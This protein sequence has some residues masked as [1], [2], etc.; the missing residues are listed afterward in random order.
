MPLGATLAGQVVH[1]ALERI[2]ESINSSPVTPEEPHAAV[3]GAS[4][5]YA[6]LRA[7]GGISA[8]VE[9]VIA[10]TVNEHRNNPRLAPRLEELGA[11]LRRQVPT[12]RQRVQQFLS[13]VDLSGV[14]PTRT[15]PV[16][17]T[18]ATL[19]RQ[20]LPPG[21]HAEVPLFNQEL[22]W[23][24]KADLLRIGIGADSPSDEIID[25]KT[26][27]PKPDHALQ[28]RI[29]ALLWARDRDLNPTGRRAQ[30]LRVLYP[31]GA[32]DIAAPKTDDAL[33]MVKDELSARTAAALSLI[34]VHPA[35]A[36][37]SFDSCQWCDVRH[38][39]SAYW[40]PTTR[41]AGNLIGAPTERLDA[42]VRILTRQSSWSWQAR[43]E[44]VGA[45]SDALQVG[46]K[47]LV[48]ARPHDDHSGSLVDVGAHIRLLSAYSVA[49][50]EESGG[51]QV[52]SLSRSTEA[53]I[54]ASDGANQR[55][56]ATSLSADG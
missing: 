9:T 29:Y 28:L 40:A 20:P 37:P 21:L 42:G 38:M 13:R 16:G 4:S 36:Q 17:P 10:D 34:A 3:T 46:S 6:G 22:G 27:L 8:V 45:I 49:P 53:F 32:E 48:R 19:H 47:V 1:I 25:F 54:V 30:R 12:L 56:G 31:A 5:V 11:E 14:H 26:G 35:Q 44:E 23:Y 24:G 39:C 7:M 15:E 50:S 33:A 55:V 41:L 43:V 2:V 18:V 51:L 52:L